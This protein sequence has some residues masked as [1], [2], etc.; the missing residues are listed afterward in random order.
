MNY[1]LTKFPDQSVKPVQEARWL[2]MTIHNKPRNS[3]QKYR[4][5]ANTQQQLDELTS[6]EE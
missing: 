2:E 4:I 6:G 5:T 1:N 3:R